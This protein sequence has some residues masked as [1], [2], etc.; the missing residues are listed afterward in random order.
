MLSH[1]ANVCCASLPPET[2]PALADLRAVAGVMV[3]LAPDRLWVRWESGD[4]QVLACLLPLSGLVLYEFREGRWYRLGGHLPA[5][6]IATEGDFLRIHQ[7][8]FPAPMQTIPSR[9]GPLSKISLSLRPDPR[10]RPTTA[11]IC[12]LSDLLAWTDAIPTCRLGQLQCARNGS[13]VLVIG[14]RLPLFATS[15]RFW[16]EAILLPLGFRLE[17]D[18][19]ERLL[20]VCLDLSATELAIVTEAGI[21]VLDRSEL[22]RLNRASLRLAMAEAS[23]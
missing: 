17:P 19:P 3:R 4:E 2:L 11:M 6:E 21:D 18:L 10:P 16:G 15:Q 9:P 22:T 5:F 20:R 8:I 13:N 1:Y 14:S 23:Q 12:P 7:V